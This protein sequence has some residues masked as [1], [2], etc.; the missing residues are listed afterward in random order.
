MDLRVMSPSGSQD[1]RR[2]RAVFL[3][4]LPRCGAVDEVAVYEAHDGEVAASLR[5]LAAA[6]AERSR[7]AFPSM[8]G[9]ILP[10]GGRHRSEFDRLG[11][12]VVS[13]APVRVSPQEG[14]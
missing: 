14:S 7:G 2:N 1:G 12:A 11:P 5:R 8:P 10:A 9:G 6:R 13:V 3:T 4:T